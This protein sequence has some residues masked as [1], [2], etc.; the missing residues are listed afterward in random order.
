MSRM[1]TTGSPIRN[2]LAVAWCVLVG[3]AFLLT[4]FQAFRASPLTLDDAAQV[5]LQSTYVGC[6]VLTAII[7]IC[8]FYHLWNRVIAGR[9]LNE[10]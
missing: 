2:A 4:Q 8:D 7:V 3:A 6:L 10:Q 5:R 9:T 1:M